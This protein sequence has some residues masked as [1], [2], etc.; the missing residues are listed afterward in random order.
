MFTVTKDA[1][2]PASD[3]EQCFYCRQA[4]GAN[5]K[6][7]CV[8]VSKMVKVRAVIEYEVRV[9]SCWDK[10]QVEFHRND[11][12]W[13]ADNMISELD[14]FI[15]ENHCLCG[16]VHFEMIKDSDERFLHES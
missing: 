4:M 15:E 10:A 12:S 9:P 6:D 11:G 7:D 16:S 3:K 5:H 14:E 1:M 2:R 13:C 8:L